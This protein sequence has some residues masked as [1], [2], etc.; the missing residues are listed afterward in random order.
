MDEDLQRFKPNTSLVRIFR[1][2]HEARPIAHKLLT[3]L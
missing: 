1:Y 3:C 2:T